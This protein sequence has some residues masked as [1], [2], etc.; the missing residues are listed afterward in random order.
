MF[1][2]CA[3]VFAAIL[4]AICLTGIG[5]TAAA[6]DAQ[7]PYWA[8]IRVDELNMRVGP[9]PNYH[10]TWVYRRADLPLRVLRRKEG[11][12]LVE[13]PHGDRGWVVARFLTRAR[14]AYVSAKGL[15]AMRER[16]DDNARI[17]WK[18]APGV[19]GKLGRCDSGWC[20]FDVAGRVGWVRQNSLW[21]AGEP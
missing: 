7:V 16:A 9:S 17:L 3:C 11:W 14:T 12:R 6:Q 18:A 19:I 20:R 4:T 2:R 13:D 15:V 5:G 21:G 8:S 10:I 1:K